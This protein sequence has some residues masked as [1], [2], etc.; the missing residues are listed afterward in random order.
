MSKRVPLTDEERAIF[1]WQMWVPDFGAAGQERLKG[2][3]VL[4]SRIGGLGGVVAYELAAAGVGRLILAHAGRIKPSDLNRQLLMTHDGL[5]QLR[6]E[7][8]RK[9]LLDLNPRLK[10]ETIAENLSPDNVDQWVRQSDV[11]VDC[12]PLFEERFAMNDAALR[13]GVPLVECAMF[14][15][16][17]HLFTVMPGKTACLRCLYPV[18]PPA[19]RREFPV[20]GA[21]SGAV[22][23]LGAVEALKLIAGFGTTLAGQMLTGDLRTMEFRKI[24]LRRNPDCPACGSSERC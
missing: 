21:V 7:S 19:W 11:V 13:H 1:E 18:Q 3:T 17:T 14:D 12:A 5:G 8:A 2:A 10:L 20:F 4:V 6:V 9:R 22:A 16:E 23:C 15:M 24:T